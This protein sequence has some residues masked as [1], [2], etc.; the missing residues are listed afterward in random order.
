MKMNIMRMRDRERDGW[1]Y[2][3]V[4]PIETIR[5]RQRKKKHAS[6]IKMDH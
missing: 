4:D 1:I 5:K 2:I 6:Y 3:Y